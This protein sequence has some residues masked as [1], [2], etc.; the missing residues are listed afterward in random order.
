MLWTMLY[1]P[2]QKNVAALS[3]WRTVGL[4]R[5]YRWLHTGNYTT[6]FCKSII[7]F[8]TLA[9]WSV[10]VLIWRMRDV[11]FIIIQKFI[12][13]VK[14]SSVLK[15]GFYS[16][17]SRSSYFLGAGCNKYQ[18]QSTVIILESRVRW[19]EQPGTCFPYIILEFQGAYLKKGQAQSYPFSCG[20]CN[21]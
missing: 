7:V 3:R 15:N 21:L 13:L 1:F 20:L 5:R 14:L 11:V 12:Y 18:F 2:H 17:R 19:S 4:Q 8:M 16:T 6:F 9:F 10:R